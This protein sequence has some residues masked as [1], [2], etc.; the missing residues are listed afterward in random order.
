MRSLYVCNP[1]MH[2]VVRVPSGPN[3]ARFQNLGFGHLPKRNE[4]KIVNMFKGDKMKCE[5]FSFK[6]GENVQSGSWRTIKDCPSNNAWWMDGY[7]VCANG[8]MYWTLSSLCENKS[9]L[10]LNLEN[11]EFSSICYPVH[12]NRKY[13]FLECVGL[14]GDL[15]VVGLSAEEPKT[16]DI[17][18]SN[19]KEKEVW[20]IECRVDLFPLCPKFIIPT[21]DGE[22]EEILVHISEKDLICYNVRSGTW[23][24]VDYYKGM[25]TY[26]KP[27]L[28]YDSLV[29]L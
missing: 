26:N 20:G 11:E 16:I 21:C 22:S 25:K 5:I 9:I 18:A 8:I 23:R 24:R 6:S 4:Y 28:Y 17:W 14:M 19:D 3:N 27:C 12:G 7:P 2:R 15:R 10:C 13:S 29:P 1:S